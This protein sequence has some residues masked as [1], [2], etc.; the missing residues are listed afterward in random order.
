MKK[1]IIITI[2]VIIAVAA[3][4][5]VIFWK[6]HIPTNEPIEVEKSVPQDST[7]AIEASLNAIDVSPSADKDLRIIDEDLNSL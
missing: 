2:C 1:N 6:K 3:V 4:L 7:G 5:V